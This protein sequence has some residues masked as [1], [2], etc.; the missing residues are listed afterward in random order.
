MQKWLYGIYSD[1]T[2]FFVS[3]PYPKKSED[4]TIGLQMSKDAKPDKV[5]LRFYEFGMEQ[6]R[7]MELVSGGDVLRYEVTVTIKE[8]RFHYQFMIAMD[9]QL[10]YYTQ[11]RITDYIPD[12]A[13]DFV[14]LADF[15]PADWVKSAV[16]YQIYPE[17][18]CN[19]NPALSVKDGEYVYQGYPTKAYPWNAPAPD[20]HEG[21]NLDF[22]GGDLEGI[23]KK[24]DYLQE[25]GV[26]AIYLNPIFYSPSSHRYDS[27]D[28]FQ[29][30]P[31]LGGDEALSKLTDEMH[32]RGMRLMLDI[33]I[34]HT[35]S[36]AKWFNKSGAFYDKSQGAYHNPDCEEREFYFIREDGSYDMWAGVPT[37]PKLNFGSAKLRDTI[38]RDSTSVLKKWLT[39]PYDIDGWR[40]DV[41]DC[42]ARNEELDVHEEVLREIRSHLKE[43]KSDVYL[44]AEDWVDCSADLQGDR[45]DSTMNYFGCGRPVREFVGEDDLV[46]SRWA[47][48]RGLKGQMTAAQLS[49]RICQF[50]GRMPGA[51]AYQMFN[52]LDSHDVP[53]LHNNEKIDDKA[54]EVAVLMMF[55]LPGT[56]NV[57][58][59]DEVAIAGKT[60]AVEFARYPMDWEWESKGKARERFAFY[61]KLCELKTTNE[62]L[63]DGSFQ[64]LFDEGKVLAYARFTDEQMLI[65]I[66]S[67][68]EESKDIQLRIGDYGFGGKQVTEMLGKDMAV[69]EKGGVLTVHVPAK[70]SFLLQLKKR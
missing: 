48:L 43:Q 11:Y 36:D 32:K 13:R 53:R 45:W 27:L 2:K 39:P 29:I 6:F 61:Q 54:V 14:L 40:F 23:V 8:N 66:C 56:V 21:R 50:L 70:E 9:G 33:S 4:V 63:G 41:A 24:L 42:L 28:Y 64:V 57:Y 58:Y 16:F 20:Y 60:D 52:L 59:G 10:Y 35:S 37:M 69:E 38:Y 49:E 34:N 47:Q 22:F 5:L 1:T 17:R 25:L 51:V 55:T 12:E 19:G 62:A 44:L 7:P 26:N 68:E 30:D 46:E 18:F 15:A 3:N 31:H 65:T 67:M